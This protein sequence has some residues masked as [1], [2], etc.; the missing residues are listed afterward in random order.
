M[1]LSYYFCITHV[2]GK[3]WLLAAPYERTGS[4]EI[5]R[6][7]YKTA[8]GFEY[9]WYL[10]PGRAIA[11]NGSSRSILGQKRVGRNMKAANTQFGLT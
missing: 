11:K 3:P 1:I 5:F 9:T 2:S 8:V 4:S 7:V 6:Y 10:I